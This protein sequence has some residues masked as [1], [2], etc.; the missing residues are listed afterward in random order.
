MNDREHELLKRRN[1]YLLF[2]R[3][4]AWIAGVMVVATLSFV[5]IETLLIQQTVERQQ[6]VN[7]KNADDRLQRAINEIEAG[8]DST[9][10]YV[11]CVNQATAVH[12]ATPE[13]LKQCDAL[14]K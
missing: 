2:A 5:A 7:Q 3:V 6:A 10:Q 12:Q 14:I 11:V 8:G 9:R 4:L 13:E 1:F